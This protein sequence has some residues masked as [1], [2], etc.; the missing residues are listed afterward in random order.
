MPR[1]RFAVLLLLAAPVLAG[2]G[3][4]VGRHRGGEVDRP[5]RLRVVT[6]A[7]ASLVREIELSCTVEAMEKADLCAR[8]PG[9]VEYLP[10]DID[11]GRYV[12][13]PHGN[14]GG[15]KLIHL[16][17][18]DLEALKRQKEALLEQARKQRILADEALTVARKE[19][20][21]TEAQERRFAADFK[22]AKLQHERI[23]ELVRRGSTQP[24]RAQ[25]TERQAEAALA[26]WQSA[27]AQI[28]TRKAK[29]KAL[30]A[31]VQVAASKVQVAEADLHSATVQL[32]YAIISAPFD[33][34]ITKRWVDRGATIKD[35]NTPLLTVMR[36][37]VV[38]VLLDVP[39]R[40][41][42]LVNATEGRPN[43]DGRGDPVT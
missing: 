5:P 18:P 29:I 35:A 13:G 30:E 12:A 9:V 40:D 21:E 32:G 36:T 42:P 38:R 25:E 8:V 39:E 33:G 16:A 6:P 4:K 15:E 7:R 24:E 2:C 22:L 20:A 11:I 31:D 14:V 26:A 23:S 43:A 1:Y 19:L 37:D 3:T 27:Q 10:P 28:E 34:I 41:V 17:V